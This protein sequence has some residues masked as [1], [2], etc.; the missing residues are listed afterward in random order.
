MSYSVYGNDSALK[1]NQVPLYANVAVNNN[2]VNK[3]PFSNNSNSHTAA[4]VSIAALLMPTNTLAASV[5]V[6]VPASVPV[7]VSVPVYASVPAASVPAASVSHVPDAN[8]DSEY[9]YENTDE[10]DANSP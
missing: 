3:F 4:P 1:Y 5:P 10:S 9:E 6:S 7:S 8:D 2:L